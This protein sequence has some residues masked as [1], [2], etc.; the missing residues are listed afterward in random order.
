MPGGHYTIYVDFANAPGIAPGTPVKYSGVL[1]GRVASVQIRQG[2]PEPVH[3]E[4][5]IETKYKILT[6]QTIQVSSGLLGD[7]ELDVVDS[8]ATVVPAA[9]PAGQPQTI[10]PEGS[11]NPTVRGQ[12]SDAPQA[13]RR[14]YDIRS[15]RPDN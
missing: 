8:P 9:I 3:A 15:T 5:E 13:R 11:T 1:I 4:L 2:V 12:S 7:T 10:Q 6:S 14:S